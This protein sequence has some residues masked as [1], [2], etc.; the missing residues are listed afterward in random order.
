MMCPRLLA[1]TA[2]V[3]GRSTSTTHYQR[4]TMATGGWV[5]GGS[6]RASQLQ[7]QHWR[8]LDCRAICPTVLLHPPTAHPPS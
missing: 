7:T 6:S 4:L 3:R 8:S 1:P 2:S 5:G